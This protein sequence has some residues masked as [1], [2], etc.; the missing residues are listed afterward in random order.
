MADYTWMA[1]VEELSPAALTVRAQLLSPNDDGRLLW[2]VF[3]PRQDVDSID[4][5]EV[6]GTDA[7]PVADRREWSGR[8]R[9][10]PMMTPRLKELTMVPIESYDRIDE[11]EMQRLRERTLGG[12]AEQIR[13]L[14]GVSIPERTDRLAMADYRRLELDAFRAWALG[15]I[16]QRDPQT[17]RGYTAS[18]GIDTGRYQTASTP[19]SDPGVNAYDEFLAWYEDAIE[20]SG[21]PAG[22]LMRLSEVRTIQADAPTLLGG[23]K[24]TR[25]QLEERISDDVGQPFRFYV[26]EQSLDPFTDGGLTTAREKVWPAG[27]IAY[28][29]AGNRIGMTA[30]APVTRAMDL[31]D[32]VPDAG[33]DIRGV[34]VFHEDE[35]IGRGL[36]LEAQLN[37]MPIPN[38]QNVDVIKVTA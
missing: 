20:R 16:T 30:F 31:S 7:R 18:Y 25:A 17:G 5:R 12:S 14:I 32:Q 28:V 3:F 15:T 11:Y 24:M 26:N 21:T 29:P 10:I 4:M 13:N 33:I 9:L 22:A 2:D 8:G 27:T 6:V 19:W 34:T 23:V 36:T 38:E 35:N 1:A 37:A